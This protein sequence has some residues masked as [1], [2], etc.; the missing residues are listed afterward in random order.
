MK[1][2]DWFHVT[3]DE[4][5]IHWDVRSPASASW[6]ADVE[7]ASIVRICFKTSES[8]DDS[9]DI[10]LFTNTRSE[11]YVVPMDADGG[12]T[13]WIE[14]LRRKLFDSELAIEAISTSA[15]VF[16]WPPEN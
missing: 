15:Q 3:F 16:C 1:I 10:Y 7:W 9:D 13:L 8:Y 6:T 12:P 4:Q 2:S 14:I 5:Q 11:S